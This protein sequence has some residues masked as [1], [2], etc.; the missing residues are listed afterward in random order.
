[1][2]SLDTDDDNPA[3]SE[4]LPFFTSQLCEII[5]IFVTLSWPFGKLW[6]PCGLPCFFLS[7]A[8]LSGAV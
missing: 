6:L 8:L 1:M 7:P 4:P 5:F 3:L 2:F